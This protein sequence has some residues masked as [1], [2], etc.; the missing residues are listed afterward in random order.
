MN[1]KAF[2]LETKLKLISLFIYLFIKQSNI[3]TALNMI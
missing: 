2:F 3:L 1:F